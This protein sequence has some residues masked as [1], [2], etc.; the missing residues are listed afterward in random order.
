MSILDPYSYADPDVT[1]IKHISFR[2]KLDFTVQRIQG[3]AVYQLDRPVNGKLVLDTRNLEIEA[4]ESGGQ[5]FTWHMSDEHPRLGQKL[6]IDEMNGIDHFQIKFITRPESQALQWIDPAQTAGKEHPFLYSQCQALNARSIFPCQDTPAVRFTSD[7]QIEVM[8]PLLAVMAAAPKGVIESGETTTTYGFEM[9]QPI[10][11]YLFAL[12]AGN[13][14]SRNLS[15]RCRIYAEP[16]QIEAAAWEFA[17]TEEHVQ[18]AEKLFGPYPWDRYDMLLLPPSY[19]YGGMENPRLTFLTP[20]L[21]VGDRSQ[22]NVVVHEL[23]HSWTGNLVTN[24]TWQDFWLNEGWTVYAEQRIME[25][26]EGQDYANLLAA[27]WTDIMLGQMKQIGM[28]SKTTQLKTEASDQMGPMDALT[29]VPY[30]KGFS[31][32][33][34]LEQAV[35]RPAF[36]EFISKYIN[37]FRFTALTTE[38]FLDFLKQELPQAAAEVDLDQWVYQPGFPSDAPP[39]SSPL[40]ARI[41]E[42]VE[43]FSQGQLP[44]K[45]EISTWNQYQVMRYLNQIPKQ[46]TIENC[47]HLDQLF[48]LQESRNPQ[49]LSAFYV[50]SIRSGDDSIMP[51]VE[52]FV[53]QVGRLILIRPIFLALAETE[54]SRD[55]ARPLFE[56]V[57]S[58]HHAITQKII[59]RLLNTAEL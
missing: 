2:M 16:E 10:P 4:I 33:K 3:T 36:D 22:V 42:W 48:G 47:H 40:L 37:K 28:D 1:Q 6:T 19:P 26:L 56:R 31:F 14:T 51:R 44:S 7:A 55:Q 21:L 30:Y 38:A 9:P 13:L 59:D 46:I 12:A 8:Q 25:A 23:A 27:H 29:W 34:R 43:S 24:A 15:D 35:G 53:E 5:S 18:Q 50:I 32:L 45:N 54:W 11:S 58:L 57:R 20:T 41:D 52:A 49:S 17:L 39:L